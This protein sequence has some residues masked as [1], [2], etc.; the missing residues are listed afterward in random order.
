MGMGM[1]MGMGGPPPGAYHPAMQGYASQPAVHYGP[2]YYAPYVPAYAPP[3]AAAHPQ[4]YVFGAPA[5]QPPAA[6]P[7][8][9]V[10]FIPSAPATQQ[11]PPSQTR[12]APSPLQSAG[13]SIAKH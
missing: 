5:A 3:Y 10:M 4:A 12:V 7:A 13:R 1:G 8:A 6:A 11:R 9:G 2:T